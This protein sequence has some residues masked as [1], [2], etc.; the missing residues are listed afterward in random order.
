M[1]PEEQQYISAAIA[2]DTDAYRQLIERYQQA[3]FRFCVRLVRDDAEAEDIVQETFITAYAQLKRYD[4]QFRFST[5][6]FVIAKRK[7]F[8]VLRKAQRLVHG[9]QLDETPNNENAIEHAEAVLDV[10]RAVAVLPKNYRTVVEMYYWDD[11]PQQEIARV[12]GCNVGVVKTRLLRAKARN[13]F[14]RCKTRNTE[15][16]YN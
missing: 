11:M 3:L 16:K 9:M 13:D 12:L 4:S 6:L 7:S 14:K 10:R 8:N 2:G 5:W 15:D 1:D